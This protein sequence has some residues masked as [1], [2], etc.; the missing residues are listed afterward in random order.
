MKFFQHGN[1]EICTPNLIC[2]FAREK[3][4]DI[5]TAQDIHTPGTISGPSD[6]IVLNKNVFSSP[7]H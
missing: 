3:Y 6:Q 4:L 5:Q 2:Y 7:L 1:K